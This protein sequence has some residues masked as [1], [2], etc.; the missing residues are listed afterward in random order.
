M[1]IAFSQVPENGF[2]PFWIWWTGFSGIC[3]PILRAI[4]I[5]QNFAL[6]NYILPILLPALGI[7]E[8]RAFDMPPH[9]QM[10]LVQM[11]LIRGTD[12]KFWKKPYKHDW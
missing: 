11:L 7:L 12:R 1:E 4:P 2:I 8:F 3:L 6:I 10:S 5:V 9:K